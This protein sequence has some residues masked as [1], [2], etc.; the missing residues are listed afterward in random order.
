MLWF[1]VAELISLWLRGKRVL[2]CKKM[3][4]WLNVPCCLGEGGLERET[5]RL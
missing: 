2:C 3:T 4:E 1:G 5:W